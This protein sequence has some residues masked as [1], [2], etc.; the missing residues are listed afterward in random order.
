[1]QQALAP[2]VMQQDA[3]G[4]QKTAA[5]AFRPAD[6]PPVADTEKL[7]AAA[8][9]DA[10]S[11]I[12][13]KPEG[14]ADTPPLPPEQVRD[15]RLAVTRQETV[16]APVGQPPVSHQAA[17]RIIAEL[18]STDQT[19]APQA[20][21]PQRDA[22]PAPVRMLHLQLQPADL[23]LLTVRL[24][25]RESGLDIK[26]EAAEHRTARLLEGDREMLSDMLR[27]AGYV[28]DG[29]S[30]QFQ[31]ADKPAPAF[32]AFAGSGAD[33]GPQSGAQSQAGGAQPDTQRGNQSGRGSDQG[34]ALPANGEEGDPKN[35]ARSADGNLYL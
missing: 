16:F 15:T 24:S 19:A 5:A 27:T 2:A 29:L 10:V 11:A 32:Q 33:N 25:L 8:E 34:G 17:E 1:V 14:D 23:G 35:P 28:V 26:L 30:V 4:L 21:T 13:R 22:T 12:A 20:A 7:R 18:K 9:T 31:S 3:Q 6:K